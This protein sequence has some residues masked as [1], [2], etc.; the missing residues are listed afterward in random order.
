MPA[1]GKEK[2]KKTIIKEKKKQNL[3]KYNTQLTSKKQVIET[4]DAIINASIL[5]KEADEKRFFG[6]D[7]TSDYQKC[8]TG[9]QTTQTCDQKRYYAMMTQ[10]C[11]ENN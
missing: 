8:P 11:V 7:K 4:I 1:I 5:T 3:P 2:K 9:F 10:K 6:Y